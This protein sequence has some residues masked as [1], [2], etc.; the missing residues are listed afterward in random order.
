MLLVC[1]LHSTIHCCF[2]HNQVADFA[3]WERDVTLLVVFR[4]Y[5]EIQKGRRGGKRGRIWDVTYQST[6]AGNEEGLKGKIS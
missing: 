1:V 6:A 2:L 5:M 4:S 3:I